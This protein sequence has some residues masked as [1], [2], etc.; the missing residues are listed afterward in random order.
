MGGETLYCAS[1][2]GFYQIPRGS[3]SYISAQASVLVLTTPGMDRMDSTTFRAMSPM[4]SPSTL[5]IRSL[6]PQSRLASVTHPKLVAA[7][8]TLDS[9]PGS[10]L[11]S[12]YPTDMSEPSKPSRIKV[13]YSI[14]LV[15]VPDE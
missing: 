10:T 11:I 6:S 1:I 3:K 7:S 9:E 5:T 15:A 8:H 2:Q 13:A 14:W 12:T 4:S